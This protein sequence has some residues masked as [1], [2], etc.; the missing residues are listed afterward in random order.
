MKPNLNIII[1]NT[2]RRTILKSLLLENA[3]HGTINIG[4]FKIE[5]DKDQLVSASLKI[6]RPIKFNK[7]INI[8]LSTLCNYLHD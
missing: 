1:H 6:D 5:K 8:V 4:D 7:L 2:I 3:N